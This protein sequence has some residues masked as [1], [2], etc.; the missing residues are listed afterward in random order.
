MKGLNMGV[1][2]IAEAG[3]NHNG[4][5]CLAE[6]L[7]EEVAKT[8]C[9]A[10]KFQTFRTE[11]LVTITAGKAGYQKASTGAAETQFNMLKRLEL[12]DGD[13]S[14]LKAVCEKNNIE[15]LSTPFDEGSVDL[16]ERLA[17]KRYK[18]SS[19]DLTN[20]RLLQYVARTGKPLIIST[21]MS[22]EL[23]IT[24]AITWVKESGND[25]ITLMHCT[26]NYPARYE[27]INMKAM[28][29]MSQLY[30][31]PVGYSDHTPGITIPIM[32]VALG[33]L[34]IEKHVTISKDLPGPDH[35]AS[36]NIK[37]LSEMVQSIRNVEKAFGNGE[38]VPVKN[39]YDTRIAARK[40]IVITK[41]LPAGHILT[42]EDLDIKRPG[43]GIPPKY[44]DSIPGSVLLKTV[45]QDTT[46]H[47]ED[48]KE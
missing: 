15:F 1:F 40:S 14:Y 38:K 30:H 36:L 25:D 22:N 26:S 24:D 12:A 8:G 41:D 31:L 5:I 2:I 48:I 9:D 44:L 27:D 34:T 6:K 7:I 19:G 10:I 35:K 17:V 16:L 20:K 4:D 21:G 29:N 13:F 18:L 39:E 32:A 37:E 33:A 23:E 28:Q 46:L 43:D 42:A 3:V 45:T 11:H 47:F